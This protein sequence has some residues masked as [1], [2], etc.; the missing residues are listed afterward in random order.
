EADEVPLVI[1]TTNDERELP[2]AF[3][4]RCAVHVL[5]E[6]KSARLVEIARQHF[7]G[8]P[9]QVPDRKQLYESVAAELEKYR[10]DASKPRERR[11]STAEYLDAVRACLDLQIHTGHT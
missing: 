5:E 9:P 6:H 11:P 8:P 10:A 2:A 1:I 7:D 3:Y 4:R